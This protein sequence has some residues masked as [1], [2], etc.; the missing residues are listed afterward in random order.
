MAYLIGLTGG[1]ATGKSTVASQIAERFPVIDAD[2]VVRKLEM[3]GEA[4]YTA[5]VNEWGST[6]LNTD[7]E[8]NR[9]RLAALIFNDDRARKRLNQLLDPLIRAKLTQLLAELSAE[10]VVFVDIPLLFEQE[11]QQLVDEIWLVYAPKSLQL[12]RLMARN[13]YSKSESL[14]RINAQ[15]PI[16][17]KRK[18]ADVVIDN[19]QDLRQTTAEV[20][21]KLNQLGEQF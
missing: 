12:T 3:K 18:L 16:E 10:K 8:L 5:I 6:I 21:E 11:Y 14:A 2:E 13:N 17:D 9:S 1:I 20:L 19:S 15:M 4:A 7:G